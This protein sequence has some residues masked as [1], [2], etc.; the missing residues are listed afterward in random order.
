MPRKR[1]EPRRHSTELG[2]NISLKECEDYPWAVEGDNTCI[3]VAC[4]A[5]T[6]GPNGAGRVEVK[7]KDK[8]GTEHSEDDLKVGFQTKCFG[9]VKE[10][11]LHAVECNATITFNVC[12]CEDH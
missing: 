9:P 5:S 4:V 2:R 8:D 3:E 11:V 7:W 6:T 12:T 1:H 10:F